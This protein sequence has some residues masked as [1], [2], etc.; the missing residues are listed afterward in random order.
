M[1]GGRERKPGGAYATRR[2]DCGEYQTV[3]VIKLY[4]ETGEREATPDN[5]LQLS[6][7]SVKK[8]KKVKPMAAVRQRA[9]ARAT[10]PK[11]ARFN[12]CAWA[13]ASRPWSLDPV[14]RLSLSTVWSRH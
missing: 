1:E 2:G 12:L 4:R 8:G 5:Q 13:S 3:F 11:S 6:G 10:I 9:L 7:R 14:F